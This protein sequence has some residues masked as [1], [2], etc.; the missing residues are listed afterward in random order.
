MYRRQIFDNRPN[1][2][3]DQTNI[4][5]ISDVHIS[6]DALRISNRIPLI[7]D[8]LVTAEAFIGCRA[9]P[10]YKRAGC[11]GPPGRNAARGS[12]APPHTLSGH[13]L[14][15][16]ARASP[17]APSRA[18]CQ[19]TH[20]TALRVLWQTGSFQITFCNAHFASTSSCSKFAGMPVSTL[21]S[22]SH[23]FPLPA[24]RPLR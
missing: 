1:S 8:L 3:A 16:L 14:R 20:L 11:F 7:D 9:R 4:A 19:R 23:E 18:L 2:G 12:L 15:M 5:L 13:A 21:F 22:S 24:H 17:F 6:I 10:H